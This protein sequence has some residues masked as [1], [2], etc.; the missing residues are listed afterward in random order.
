MKAGKLKISV[1][2]PAHNE[3]SCIKACLQGIL[4]QDYKNKEVIVVND[5]S[6]DKTSAIAKSLKVKVLDFPQGHSAA[7]AR[8]AGARKATGDVLYFLDA[9]VIIKD[10]QFLSKLAEDFKE[11]D[12][13][14]LRIRPEKPKSFIQKCLSISYAQMPFGDVRKVVAHA[15]ESDT[16]RGFHA[17]RRD[18]FL[19]LGG[20]DEKIFYFEDRDLHNKFYANGHKA[21]YDPDLVMYS[22]D[23]ENWHEFARQARWS[24]RGVYEYYRQTG[25]FHYRAMLFWGLYVLLGAGS[26]LVLPLPFFLLMNLLLVFWIIRLALK[27][28]DIIHS[29]GYIALHF[30]RTVIVGF[31]IARLHAGGG[32]E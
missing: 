8:N 27:S 30:A 16:V 25:V 29:A 10:P 5:G 19:R 15:P 18:L 1:I 13:V 14:I 6:A 17:I 9:D 23:P 20:F 7:F 26:I 22:I 2:I 32:R 12:A 21:L 4:N 3:E 31:Q 28:G 11:A 24:G